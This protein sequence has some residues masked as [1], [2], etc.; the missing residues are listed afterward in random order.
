MSIKNLL[1]NEIL[2]FHICLIILVSLSC[3]YKHYSLFKYSVRPISPSE[4]P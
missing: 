3:S 2:L 4:L 1:M